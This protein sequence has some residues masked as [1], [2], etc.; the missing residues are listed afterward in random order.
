MGKE[1][2]HARPVGEYKPGQFY[3]RH[4]RQKIDIVS[5]SVS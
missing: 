3:N 2:T 1:D 4:P 5:Q